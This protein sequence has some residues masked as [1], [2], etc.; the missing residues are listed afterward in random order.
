MGRFDSLKG[1]NFSS[2]TDEMKNNNKPNSR[3]RKNRNKGE[4]KTVESKGEDK[5][6]EKT[7]EEKELE[8]R[9]L[10]EKAQER[11]FK[12]A[13]DKEKAEEKA[14]IKSLEKEALE[15]QPKESEW[16]KR[17]NT[18]KEEERAVI[19]LNDPKFWD[20]P[21]WIGPMFIRTDK[22]A[23]ETKSYLRKAEKGNVSAF[24]IPYN[25]PKYSR[26]EIHWYD[27][28]EETFTPFEWQ[29]MSAY[30]DDT[31]WNECFRRIYNLHERRR[32]ESNRHYEENSELDG[33]AWAEIEAEKYEEYCRKFDEKYGDNEITNVDDLEDEYDENYD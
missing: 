9:V 8:E 30:E 24:I 20:G 5:P 17:I 19:N 21:N 33:F 27:S 31:N 1:N 26:D 7:K 16:I 12:K 13:L 28:W 18:R 32:E 22:M 14:L 2:S 29:E 10:E 3:R 11:A 6:K 15:E 23:E 25:N 4:E